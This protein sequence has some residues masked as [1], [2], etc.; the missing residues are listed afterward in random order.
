M[1]LSA[2]HGISRVRRPMWAYETSYLK[3]DLRPDGM[4]GPWLHLFDRGTQEAID[5]P[6]PQTFIAEDTTDDYVAYEGPLD[7][8]D[9]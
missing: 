9:S 3:I 6:T 4:R 5:E 7:R 2:K 8:E 1:T